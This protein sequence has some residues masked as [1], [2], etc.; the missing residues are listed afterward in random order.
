MEEALLWRWRQFAGWLAGLIGVVLALFSGFDLFGRLGMGQE[1][2]SW[3][4]TAYVLVITLAITIAAGFY[5]FSAMRKERYANIMR[6]LHA[7]AHQA[8]DISTYVVNMEPKGQNQ[9]AYEVYANTAKSLFGRLLDQVSVI[10]SMLTSTRCRAAIKLA[11][12]VGDQF[13][14]CTLTRDHLSKKACETMDDDRLRHNR[15]PLWGNTHLAMLISTENKIWHFIS[16]NL[17]KA[18]RNK[19]YVTTS[20]LAY[21]N[22]KPPGSNK[23]VLPYRSCITCVIG[24]A[25]FDECPHLRTEIPG[26]LTVDS[27]SRGVFEERWDKELMFLI[28]DALFAPLT[29]YLQAVQRGKDAPATP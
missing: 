10:F 20:E 14:V 17:V 11:Y 21:V 24:Q 26:F 1:P 18:L 8:R 25:K 6:A 22:G 12:E 27:E 29:A 19:Q 5:V 23:W 3:I 2:R 4:P 16:N 7:I 15:D 9:L 13:Y 28:A